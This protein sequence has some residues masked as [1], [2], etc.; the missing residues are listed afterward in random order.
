MV[1]VRDQFGKFSKHNPPITTTYNFDF[2]TIKETIT[3]RGGIRE[4]SIVVTDKACFNSKESSSSFSDQGRSYFVY[5]AHNIKG[6][7]HPKVTM[8]LDEG[9]LK[10]LVGSHNL[11][12]AGVKYN[13]EITSYYEIPLLETFTEIIQG[14]SNFVKRLSNCIQSDIT[15]KKTMQSLVECIQDLDSVEMVLKPQDSFYFLHSFRKP[16][17]EQVLELVPNISRATV[18][19]PFLSEDVDFVTDIISSLGGKA[20]FLIDPKSFS[21]SDQA[22]KAYEKNDVQILNI[23][24]NRYLHAKLFVFHT[25]NGDWTLF[26]SPNFTRKALW[27]RVDRGGNVEAS[28]L[29]APSK[30]WSWKDLFHDGVTASPI[31]W[32]ELHSI[33]KDEHEQTVKETQIERWGYE[34]PNNEGVILAQGLSDGT[35][36]YIHLLGIDKNLKIKVKKGLI[37]FK[38][39]SNWYEDTRY[40]IL[41]KTLKV[42]SSGFLNR[43]GAVMKE[44]SGVDIDDAAKLNLWFYLRR[45]RHF[46]PK[47]IYTR[48]PVEIP[49]VPLDP[50]DWRP[51]PIPVDWRPISKRI[52]MMTPKKI[53]DNATSTF[54]ESW[55]E[56]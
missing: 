52:L 7:F 51:R 26:G 54:E 25:Q 53:Y 17:F 3:P 38:I 16:I 35:V 41:D 27:Q 31:Q 23:D 20:T 40:E 28:I 2:P 9:I 34:T 24:D 10:L 39:P 45:L 21:I 47:K 43:S 30:K 19:A 36:V 29:T 56:Y 14:V 18:C 33:E 50:R 49:E 13:L 8:G 5:P 42:I 11:T 4:R 55:E 15:V 32:S 1:M 46:D 37:R 12:E 22:K 44:L 48:P 6:S